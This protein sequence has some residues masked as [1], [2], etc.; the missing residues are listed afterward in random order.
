MIDPLAKSCTP[1]K[2]IQALSQPNT[3]V[4]DR[5]GKPITGWIKVKPDGVQDAQQLADWI[6][7]GLDYAFSIPPKERR[8]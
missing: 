3:V 8:G 4:F 7:Q 6:Q 5:T 1:E 2:H